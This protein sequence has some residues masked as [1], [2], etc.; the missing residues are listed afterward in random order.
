MLGC[1]RAQCMSRVVSADRAGQHRPQCMCRVAQ[2]ASR[3]INCMEHLSL[4][5]LTIVEGLDPLDG[6][7]RYIVSKRMLGLETKDSLNIRPN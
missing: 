2:S 5:V 7:D 3:H 4:A 1:N 6:E